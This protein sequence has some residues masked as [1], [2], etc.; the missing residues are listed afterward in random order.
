M[1]L[2]KEETGM[3]LDI[4][5]IT[6]KKTGK[7]YIDEDRVS[8]AFTDRVDAERFLSSDSLAGEFCEVSDARRYRHGE[9][10]GLCYASGAER[11]ALSTGK[12]IQEIT[13]GMMPPERYYNPNLSATLNLLLTTRKKRYLRELADRKFIV[14]IRIDGNVISYGIARVK[15]REFFLLFSDTDEFSLWASS[16]EGFSPLELTFREIEGLSLDRDMIINITGSRFLLDREKI[17][18]IRRKED[19]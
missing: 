15:E 13:L 16:V 10:A 9:L 5:L 18:M 19:A 11:I 6:Y 7:P 14:P 3:D 17:G 4:R 1:S 12:E 2:R 8:H